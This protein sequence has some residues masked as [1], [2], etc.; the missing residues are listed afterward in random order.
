MGF[1]LSNYS[2][3]YTREFAIVGR[4]DEVGGNNLELHDVE[5]HRTHMD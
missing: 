3:N 2:K 5:V 1:W 4:N